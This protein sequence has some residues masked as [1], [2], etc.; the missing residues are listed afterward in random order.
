[1]VGGLSII[2]VQIAL[3]KHAVGNA[4]RGV[5]SAMPSEKRNATEGVPYRA[6][7]SNPFLRHYKRS[8][9]KRE[10]VQFGVGQVEAERDRFAGERSETAGAGKG[11]HVPQLV[12]LDRFRDGEA[13][14]RLAGRVEQFDANRS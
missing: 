5:P 3:R 11:D 6:F 10:G 13:V 1:M 4:L 12:A 8:L 14:D 7:A 2:V 9:T